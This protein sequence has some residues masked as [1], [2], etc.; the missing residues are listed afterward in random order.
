MKKSMLVL[1]VLLLALLLAI[2]AF[3]APPDK[4]DVDD[5]HKEKY[6]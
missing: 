1:L 3:A 4:V 5:E 6:I 2:P